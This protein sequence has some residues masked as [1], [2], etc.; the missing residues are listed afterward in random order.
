MFYITLLGIKL[1]HISN[2]LHVVI[3]Q[4]TEN[5]PY[6]V[7][8]TVKTLNICEDKKILKYLFLFI[9]FKVCF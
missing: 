3:F 8:P 7:L 1:S 2:G 9:N 4:A 5:L 6:M